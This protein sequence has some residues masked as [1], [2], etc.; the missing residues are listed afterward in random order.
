MEHSNQWR[1][2]KFPTRLFDFQFL[3]SMHLPIKS[4]ASFRYCP[5]LLQ[6]QKSVFDEVLA[7]G[8]T[9]KS[10]KPGMKLEK[11]NKKSG[12]TNCRGGSLKAR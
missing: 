12:K 6:V 1:C 7:S 2:V 5:D 10:S 11:Q 8:I 3:I 4:L 9:V